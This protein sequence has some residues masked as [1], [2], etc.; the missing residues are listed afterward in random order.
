M[1]QI[2]NITKK[3]EDFQL[4]N[5]LYL[6]A[7]PRRERE[8]LSLLLYRAKKGSSKF[9]AY[10]D[11]GVFVGFSSVLT[12][13]DL[14]YIQYL[15]VVSTERSKGYG[16]QILL[17]IKEA[18]QQKRIFLNMEAE[19]E[20]AKNAKQRQKRRSFYYKNDYV[21]TGLN[22]EIAKTKFELMIINGTCTAEEVRL[23]FRKYFGPLT[24]T[25]ILR[26]KVWEVAVNEC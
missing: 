14:S 11:D 4:I 10:Y 22:A 16:G 21:T 9:E 7:F 19:D 15:A 26:I 23:F 12:R 3:M 17:H 1:L 24:S 8:P 6:S 2:K 18:H 5:D 20:T 25:F 13:G